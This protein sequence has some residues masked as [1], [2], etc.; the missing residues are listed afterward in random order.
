LPKSGKIGKCRIFPT[1]I[2]PWEKSDLLLSFIT[3]RPS[4][5]KSENVGKMSD[6]KKLITNREKSENVGYNVIIISLY[7]IDGH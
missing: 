3:N 7:S 2:A 5:E 4:L 1:L 6:L